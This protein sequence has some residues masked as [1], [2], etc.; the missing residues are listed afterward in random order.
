M[1]QK[2]LLKQAGGLPVDAQLRFTAAIMVFSAIQA[3]GHDPVRII[4]ALH[5]SARETFSDM[6]TGKLPGVL[7]EEDDHGNV[8]PY[9]P[10]AHITPNKEN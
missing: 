9:V 1:A 10:V 2:R 8:T 4:D 3:D 6:L 5:R 7:H